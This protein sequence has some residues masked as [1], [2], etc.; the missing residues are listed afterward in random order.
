MRMSYI[1]IKYNNNNNANNIHDTHR[2]RQKS[3]IWGKV[4]PA[5]GEC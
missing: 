4:A 2:Q 1:R 5:P 3:S